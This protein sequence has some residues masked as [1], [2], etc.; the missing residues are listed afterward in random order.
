MLESKVTRWACL[1]LLAWWAGPALGYSNGRVQVVCGSMEPLHG[2]SPSPDPAPY[3]L[4]VDG[5]T[6]KPGARVTVT[7]LASN[8]S[9][10]FKG[11][12]LEARD[13]AAPHSTVALGSFSLLQ[14][15]V[16]QLLGCGGRQAS[17]VSHTSD[18]KKHQVQAV[19]TCPEDSPP[20][21]QFFATVVQ[22]KKLYWVQVPGPVVAVAGAASTTAGVLTPP[23]TAAG[24]PA[25]FSSEGC[26]HNKSCLREP[27]GCRPENDPD[28]FFLSFRPDAI[29]GSA[30][31]ELS[32]P[33]EGY[34]A[35]GLSLDTWMGNDDVYLC[36]QDQ[37]RVHIQ[38]AS[39]SGRTR[40]EP[41]PE[42][43]LR[44]QTGAVADGVILCRFRRDVRIPQTDQRFDLDQSY[45]LF[46]AHGRAENGSTMRHH[47]QPLISSVRALVVGPPVD[48]SGSRSPLIIKL[49]GV[50]MLAAWM[51]VVS[52]GVLFARHFRHV[53]P[54]VLLRGG[55]LW[56]QVHRG[57]MLLAVSLVSVAFTLPFLYRG[58][59]SKHAGYHPYLGCAV[60]GLCIIQPT[61]ALF[62]P[63][64]LSPRRRLFNLFHR[65][66]GTWLQMQAGVCLFLG[67]R[68]QALLLRGPQATG[69]LVGWGLWILLADLGLHFHS[70]SPARANKV[71]QHMA[72]WFSSAGNT[73][74]TG[75]N[76]DLPLV[77]LEDPSPPQTYVFEKT[78][79]LVFQLGNILFFGVLVNAVAKV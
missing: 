59:W 49:H 70:I 69:A 13:A 52:T 6:V 8:G 34:V 62:R 46:L 4:T 3:R 19:W 22:K 39:V 68:Q 20:T 16:S 37:G 11:F 1:W 44:D 60:L 79:M 17:G 26:G 35:L 33:A 64:P 51:W 43:T 40:P 67:F 50:M 75:D 14:P 58:G 57:L 41:A 55:K 25:A 29:G 32:G 53:W 38:A 5:S 7:L 45:F 66:A 74:D 36:I 31:F 21:V 77:T 18:S 71:V 30:L 76:D 10:P 42:G 54:D 65:S 12:L 24:L 27:A 47:R 72:T 2:H 28:C 23:T 73:G 61:I 9:S 78:L 56:F 15:G 48:L 63:A